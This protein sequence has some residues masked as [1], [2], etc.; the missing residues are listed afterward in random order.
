MIKNVSKWTRRWLA[1]GSLSGATHIVARGDGITPTFPIR[2]HGAV[3]SAIFDA[4]VPATVAGAQADWHDSYP[5]Q[6][7]SAGA[8]NL[9]LLVY[10]DP[11]DPLAKLHGKGNVMLV[12]AHVL[13][14]AGITGAAPPT[15]VGGTC[16][17]SIKVF[18]AALSGWTR[19][20]VFPPALAGVLYPATT[21]EIVFGTDSGLGTNLV[22]NIAPATNDLT[23]GRIRIVLLFVEV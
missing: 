16:S 8:F 5:G 15:Q 21:T 13:G 6:Y 2:E 23:A 11:L 3:K 14:G 10:G 1:R 18:G 20:A 12:G 7:P 4:D 9:G 19:T 17:M 22:L